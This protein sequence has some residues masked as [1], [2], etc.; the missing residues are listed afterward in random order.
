VD[1]DDELLAATAGGDEAALEELYDAF[2]KRLYG[3]GMRLLA[4]GGLAEE[5]VQESFVRIW[6]QAKRF[7]PAIG[8]ARTFIF[9]IARHIA[10]DLHRRP[11][12]R[13]LQLEREAPAPDAAE[14]VATAIDVERAMSTL[15]QAHREVLEV[16]H[17]QQLTQSEAAAAL[18]IPLGTVKTRA[19]HAARAV[20]EA[21]VG[22]GP[23]A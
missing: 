2:A 9:T 19:F 18:G 10:I 4:D 1:R 11:S 22:G 5:L 16:L 15:S 13:P 14:R 12:S 20:R 21:L 8:N 7:D 23:H 6:K 17:F 3:L